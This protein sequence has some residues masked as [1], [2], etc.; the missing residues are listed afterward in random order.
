MPRQSS[1][2][3][4]L[5]LSASF[6]IRFGIRSS[7]DVKA[8]FSSQSAFENVCD[9]CYFLIIRYKIEEK[10]QYFLN[11]EIFECRQPLK[12]AH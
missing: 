3:R 5:S 7:S 4:I 11:R 10:K 8:L 12:P 1:C 2:Y 6:L 9:K